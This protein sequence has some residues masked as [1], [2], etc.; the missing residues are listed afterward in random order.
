MPKSVFPASSHCSIP[1]Y[2]LLLGHKDVKTRL[3][4]NRAT[5]KVFKYAMSFAED[6][7]ETSMPIKAE[8]TKT[9]STFRV[10]TKTEP[11]QEQ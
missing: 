10:V 11:G 5:T 8:G 4:N 2:L 1:S 6:T 7:I 3:I 9:I